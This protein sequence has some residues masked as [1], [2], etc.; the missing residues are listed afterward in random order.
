MNSWLKLYKL[1][2]KMALGN[3]AMLPVCRKCH[4]EQT[5]PKKTSASADGG[6]ALFLFNSDNPPADAP[7]S[8]GAFS[9]SKLLK[10]LFA[11]WRKTAGQEI[12]KTELKGCHGDLFETHLL[13]ESVCT[14]RKLGKMMR[15]DNLDGS[16][17]RA[18][19]DAAVRKGNSVGFIPWAVGLFPVPDSVARAVHEALKAE[20]PDFYLGVVSLPHSYQFET[21]A[22]NLALP[23]TMRIRQG[24]LVGDWQ[25]KA[26]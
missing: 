3:T 4:L 19:F 15:S 10:H 7:T 14:L 21:T 26:P 6:M 9:E 12:A 17:L 23:Q 5:K 16:L 24:Q 25:G 8:Y 18:E 20:L 1:P 22:S 13:G 11:C 2:F